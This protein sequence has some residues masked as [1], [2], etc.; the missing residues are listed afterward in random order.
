M[1]CECIHSNES[2][3]D[4]ELKKKKAKDEVDELLNQHL[5]E[6]PKLHLDVRA[7]KTT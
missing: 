4:A 7:R 6:L 1:Y 2:H 3:D 5:G